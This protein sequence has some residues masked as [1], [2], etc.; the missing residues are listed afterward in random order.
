MSEARALFM[1][2][3]VAY[4]EGR[5]EAALTHF[6]GAFELSERPELLYNIAQCYDR[7]RRDDEAITAFE[8]YLATEPDADR[9][10]AVEAR[11]NAL[12]A[13]RDSRQAPQAPS[14]PAAGD[15]EPVTVTAA[16][17]TEADR[18]WLSAPTVTLGAGVVLG[19]T[20]GVLML[21]GKQLGDE[22]EQ[23]PVGSSRAKLQNDLDSAE[24]QWVLGQ[25][26]LG[27]GVAAMAGGLVWLLVD[28]GPTEDSVRVAVGP[29]SVQVGGRF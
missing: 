20:G 22:V 1:A 9:R 26:V 2:G 11:L 5:Y 28:S 16:A 15:A 14:E 4:D 17:T 12:R 13:A 19:V 24:Q 6:T 3:R 29:G 8:R 18:G 25:V 27:V 21:L 23:A 10:A 7:L